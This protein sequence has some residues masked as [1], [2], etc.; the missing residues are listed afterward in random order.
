MNSSPGLLSRFN[1]TLSFNN[2]TDEEL[3]YICKDI[4]KINGYE[5]TNSAHKKLISQLFDLKEKDSDFS[6]FLPP[7]LSLARH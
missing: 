5:I 3:S 4:A 1:K 2:F 6:F 7:S